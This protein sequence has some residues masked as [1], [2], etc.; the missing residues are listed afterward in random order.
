MSSCLQGHPVPPGA[1]S[2]AVCGDDVRVRCPKGH[3]NGADAQFCETCGEMLR[4]V[5]AS[6]AVT[7]HSDAAPLLEYSSGVFADFILGSDGHVL[8]DQFRSTSQVDASLAAAKGIPAEPMSN[9]KPLEVQRRY[10]A[11]PYAPQ[12]SEPTKPPTPSAGRRHPTR[13]RE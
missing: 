6:A 10:V 3:Q 2:C 12:V 5:R 8:I 9:G 11:D 13:P 7:G 4:A 1:E